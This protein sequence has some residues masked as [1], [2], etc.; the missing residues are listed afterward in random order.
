VE[1][2]NIDELAKKVKFLY[3][4]KE[5]AIQMGREAEIKFKNLYNKDRHIESLLKIFNGLIQ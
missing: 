5:K 3:F 2:N 4:N 1:R